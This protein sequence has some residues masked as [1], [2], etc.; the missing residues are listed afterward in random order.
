MIIVK[1]DLESIKKG[2]ELYDS[3]C[4]FCHDPYGTEKIVGPA[5]KGILKNPFLPASKKPSTPENIANQIRN[6]YRDM[7]SF[8]YLSNEQISDIIAFL[9]TL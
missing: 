1:T 6:P 7:P 9:N 8:S 3:K 2:R 5:H 4:S